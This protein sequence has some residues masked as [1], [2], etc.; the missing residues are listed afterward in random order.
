MICCTSRGMEARASP[1]NCA[2]C[3]AIGAIAIV[4]KAAI[5]VV[6]CHFLK[7]FNWELPESCALPRKLYSSLKS[8]HLANRSGAL[9]PVQR[10]PQ[11]PLQN[12]VLRIELGCL[13][14]PFCIR[15]ISELWNKS[16]YLTFGYR[17]FVSSSYFGDGAV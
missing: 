13:T 1:L 3:S 8:L 16:N 5:A 15:L 7:V 17:Y 10:T 6:C 14:H 11:S 12:L 9:W 4:A 2:A